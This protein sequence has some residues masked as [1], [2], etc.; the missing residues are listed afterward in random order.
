MF[1]SNLI[2]AVGMSS[3][4]PF[5]PTHLAH[6]GVE[7]PAAIAR[8]AGLAAGAAPFSAALMAPVW[9]ALGDR[10]GRR[11]MVLRALVAIAFF[12]GMMSRATSPVELC[13]LRVGQGVF[14]GFIAPSQTLVSVA[15][16]VAVQGRVSGSLQSAL[17]IGSIVGPVV[18]AAIASRFGIQNVYLWVALAALMSALVVLGFASEDRDKRRVSSSSLSVRALLFEGW[19]DVFA[20]FSRPAM[21]SALVGLFAIQFAIG[22]VQ[23]LLALFVGDVSEGADQSLE[24]LASRTAGLFSAIAL[25]LVV[26]TPVWGWLGDRWGHRR[27]LASSAIGSALGLAL[28]ATADTYAGLFAAQVA[29][30][31][32]SAG[33]NP[34][35][36]GVATTQTADGERGSAFGAMFSARAF[37]RSVAAMLGGMGAALFGLRGVCALGAATVGLWFL[38]QALGERAATRSR[39][40]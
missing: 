8:W 28:C 22:A 13:L 33:A 19:T 16:P 26:A 37:A 15:A 40:A 31:L 5:F 35:A 39:S 10:F 36:L 11:M 38:L 14:S 29:L 27:A 18:G 34:S 32:A 20:F 30:S 24:Q 9:G 25:V 6:L 7:D 12:V 17:A 4:L 1:I 23:P 21:R 3:F 2:T